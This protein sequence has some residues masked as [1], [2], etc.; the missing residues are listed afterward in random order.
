MKKWNEIKHGASLLCGKK[1][2]YE[3]FDL[4]YHAHEYHAHIPPQD[5]NEREKDPGES[6]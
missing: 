4:A 5:G 1:T 3:Y 2:W 6:R